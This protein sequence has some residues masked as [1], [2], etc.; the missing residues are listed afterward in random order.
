MPRRNWSDKRRPQEFG[1]P[2]VE[3]FRPAP[4]WEVEPTPTSIRREV[5]QRAR[6][7]Q[8]RAVELLGRSQIVRRRKRAGFGRLAF[9]VPEGRHAVCVRCLSVLA[10]GDGP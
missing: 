8:H 2:H 5:L 7:C 4:E 9:E 3:G 6:S 1:P 10:S